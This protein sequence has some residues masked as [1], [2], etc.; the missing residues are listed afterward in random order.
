M[1]TASPNK[2][3]TVACPQCEQHLEEIARLRAEVA[4]LREQKTHLRSTRWW[5]LAA[6]G[7]FLLATLPHLA[8]IV[9]HIV[10]VDLY[11]E[12][13]GYAFWGATIGLPWAQ[14]SLI[15]IVC[16][17]HE[18]PLWKRV[19]SYVGLAAVTVVATS[20]L[21]SFVDIGDE[22]MLYLG[23][24]SPFLSVAVVIPAFLARVLRRWTLV[25]RTSKAPARPTSLATYLAV[26]TVFGVT[27]TAMKFFPWD[28]IATTA[29]DMSAY[30]LVF[31]GPLIALGLLHLWFLPNVLAAGERPSI[32]GGPLIMLGLIAAFGIGSSVAGFVIYLAYSERLDWSEVALVAAL[33]STL[34]ITAALF[35][36]AG[37]FWLRLL[38]YE[39][40]AAAGM[41]PAG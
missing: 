21:M 15:G 28:T 13:P 2:Q 24:A 16:M 14:W 8:A 18:G 26:M 11:D 3:P 10:D 4:R 5:W 22:D 36:M 9:I 37:Y 31:G 19:L 30:L 39:L 32:L 17:L 29:E 23:Y 41:N 7:V 35:N 1:T 40:R 33:P 12:W 20:L 25:H 38:G 6:M 27:F 34:I